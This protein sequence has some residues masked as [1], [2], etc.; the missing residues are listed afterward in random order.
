MLRI[1]T[2]RGVHGFAGDEL[3][4]LVA[5][6]RHRSEAVQLAIRLARAHVEK[7]YVIK[8]SGHYHGW[9]DNVMG[10]LMDPNPQGMPFG[11]DSPEDYYGTQGKDPDACKQTFILP[12]ND[13]DAVG[14]CFER[15][16]DQIAIVHCEVIAYNH[17]G[18]MPRPGFLERLK[19]LCEQYNVVLSFDEVITGFRV[20]LGGAQAKIGVTPHMATFGKAIGGGMPVSLVAGKRDILQRLEDRTV[21]GPGTFMGY[22]LGV[23]ACLETIKILE[24]DNGAVYREMDRLQ[25]RLIAG[26]QEIARRKG[27]PMLCQGTTGAFVILPG[28]ECEIAYT[29]EDM[30]ALNIRLLVKLQKTLQ[31]EGVITRSGG[32]FYLTSAHNDTDIDFTLEAF[33]RTMAKL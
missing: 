22:P 5:I 14:E 11:I 6:I 21:L 31:N 20:G 13:I 30:A 17:F 10:Q 8:F 27:V 19:E 24:A 29:E 12:W 7:R 18:L 32:T 15:Y 9:F 25:E 23:V 26:I 3:S 16:G 4:I 1:R 33:D 2:E 28:V